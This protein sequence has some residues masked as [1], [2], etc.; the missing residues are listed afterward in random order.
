MV[1][2]CKLKGVN[3]KK[4]TGHVF[5]T[6]LIILAFGSLTLTPLLGFIGTGLRAGTIF[7]NQT[8]KLY[9]ADAG[10]E[11]ASWHIKNAGTQISGGVPGDYDG[12]SYIDGDGTVSGYLPP[13]QKYDQYGDPIPDAK[14]NSV[15][16]DI[17]ESLNGA[18]VEVRI[19]NVGGGIYYVTSTATTPDDG[20]TVVTAWVNDITVSVTGD[21]S[22]ITDNAIT[23]HG[24]YTIQGGQS[25]VTPGEGE[26]HGPTSYYAGDWPTPEQLA[27]L[28][29][30]DV[31][32]ATPYSLSKLDIK[33]YSS[34]G[35]GPF[36]RDGILTIESS[37]HGETLV[38][39]DTVYITGDTVIKDNFILD[40]NGQTIFVE[41]PTAGYA[42]EVMPQVTITGSGCIIAVGS[43]KFSPTISSNADDYI[44]VLSVSGKTYMQP[45]GDF[46]GTLAG[47]TEVYL[48]NGT[49][50][51]T[52]PSTT[53]IDLNFPGYIYERY[54]GILSYKI[55]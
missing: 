25:G 29:Y 37:A 54:W 14:Y 28:Y 26:E 52:N 11:D 10:I 4:Q 49:M 18:V 22:G 53:G 2:T 55:N 15:K 30:E 48:Q 7:E 8:E 32:D 34:T 1:V 50:T 20:E 41:S 23:S 17:A 27:T 3:T 31:E 38:L 9:A 16:Y 51:W 36:Y 6:A 44:L 13:Y 21:F 43:I 19:T 24:G 5:I 12:I 39:N 42:L 46:Y 35:I 45:G 47:Q 33:D 40:M